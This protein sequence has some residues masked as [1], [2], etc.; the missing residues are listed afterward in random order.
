M[1]LFGHDLLALMAS[2]GYLVLFV[3]ILVEEA[4]LPLPIPGDLLLLFTGSL[5]AQGA[6]GLVPTLVILAMATLIGTSVLYAVAFRGGR[7]L[8]RRYGRWLRLKEERV[9]RAER[10]LGNRPISGITLLRLT[11][12][13]RIYSTLVAGLLAVPR[14]RATISFVV[15][16]LVWGGA[17]LGLGMVLGTNVNRAADTIGRVDR[18]FI[19]ALVVAVAAIGSFWVGRWAYRRFLPDGLGLRWRVTRFACG[20]CRPRLRNATVSA[21]AIGLLLVTPL[22]VTAVHTI[23]TRAEQEVEVQRLTP[24]VQR[25]LL[26]DERWPRDFRE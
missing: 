19:P 16:G 7:P 11:P 10:W 12:G 17:W 8:L 13:L 14:A 3:I 5:V 2:H 20:G 4:G 21:I 24:Q 25:V 6:L 9:D 15:S 1:N 23:S 18:L 26:I 22:L